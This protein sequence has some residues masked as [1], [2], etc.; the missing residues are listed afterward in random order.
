MDAYVRTR[1][2]WDTLY[3]K[4][5]MMLIARCLTVIEKYSN[6]KV[7]MNDHIFWNDVILACDLK[8]NICK[9]EA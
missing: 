3:S 7:Q 8:C 4:R 9:D 6:C 5:R 2:F 1:F